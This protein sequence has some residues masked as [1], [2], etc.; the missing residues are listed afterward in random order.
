MCFSSVHMLE[1]EGLVGGAGERVVGGAGG[2]TR[3]DKPPNLTSCE[4]K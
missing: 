2:G 4:Y 1:G 3:R